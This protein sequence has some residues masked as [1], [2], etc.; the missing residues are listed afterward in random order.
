MNTKEIFEETGRL[1]N[2]VTK[3][4]Q[5]LNEINNK[6]LELMDSCPHEFFLKIQDDHPRKLISYGTCFCPACGKL[7]S[8]QS[9]EQLKG[10]PFN[11]SRVVFLDNLSLITD[12]ET[13]QAIRVEVYNHFDFYYNNGNED[14]LLVNRL[15]K[16]LKSKE[17]K[18][19]IPLTLR[20]LNRNRQKE[21]K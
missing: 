1:G 11:K 7:I 16:V 8:I 4:H 12:K 10:R 21:S 3:L 15:E 13:L 6:Y 14:K 19:D 2:K 17:H 18:Y 9:L 20:K 5:E